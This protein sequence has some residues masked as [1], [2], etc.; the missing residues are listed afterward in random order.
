MLKKEVLFKRADR[1]NILITWLRAE[2]IVG[3][4]QMALRPSVDGSV[5][6]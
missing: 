6:I 2:V 3:A 5:T 4:L 1:I